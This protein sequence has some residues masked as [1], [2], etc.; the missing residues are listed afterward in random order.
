MKNSVVQNGDRE[1]TKPLDKRVLLITLYLIRSF[2]GRDKKE[3][4]FKKIE[5]HETVE[6]L[7]LGKI[8]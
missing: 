8:V 7:N 3:L 6:E 2:V 1:L 4:G 5:N